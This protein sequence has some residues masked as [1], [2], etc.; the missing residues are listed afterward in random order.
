MALGVASPWRGGSEPS[1][2]TQGG[3]EAEDASGDPPGLLTTNRTFQRKRWS[4]CLPNG[5]DPDGWRSLLLPTE[6]ESHP[7]VAFLRRAELTRVGPAGLP[8][9]VCH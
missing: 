2:R 6:C 7:A 8:P 5:R 3:A 1:A 4:S 9:C